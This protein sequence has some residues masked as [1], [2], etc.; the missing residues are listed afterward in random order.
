MGYIIVRVDD[1]KYV[2][3]PGSWHS[4]TPDLK[5]ARV[6]PTYEAAQRETCGNERVVS[7][8]DLLHSN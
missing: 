3:Q 7:L 4:Y 2:A 5:Y 6:F 1:G 8:T